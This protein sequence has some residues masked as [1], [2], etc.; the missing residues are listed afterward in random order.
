MIQTKLNFNAFAAWLQERTLEILKEDGRSPKITRRR[1]QKTGSSYTGLTF[2]DP[3]NPCQPIVNVDLFYD[4]YKK[5]E[6]EDALLESLR[7][8][9]HCPPPGDYTNYAALTENYE[10]AR[11]HLI[12]RAAS[13]LGSREVLERAPHRIIGDICLTY[14]VMVMNARDDMNTC[15]VTYEMLG[16]FGISEE[17][18]HHDAVASAEKLLPLRLEPLSKMAGAEGETQ[19]Y[20]ITNQYGLGGAAALFYPGTFEKIGKL[21]GDLFYVLPSSVHEVIV[22]RKDDT[23]RNEFLR[24]MVRS[25][26]QSHV[27]EGERLS[28]EV[29]QGSVSSGELRIV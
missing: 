14:H 8:V 5:G 12:V 19:I 6:D 1:I 11:E 24:E 3:E 4:F 20:V 27:A 7:S 21:L 18:L 23:V 28:S 17:T 2:A 22:L 29:Y 13:L 10:T 9:I 26:N 25:I 16:R 15:L